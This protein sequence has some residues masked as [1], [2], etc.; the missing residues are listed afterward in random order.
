MNAPAPPAWLERLAPASHLPAWAR[1]VGLRA[2]A[3]LRVHGLPGRRE[4]AWKYTR[5]EALRR[6][7]FRAAGGPLPVDLAHLPA[8]RGPRLVFAGGYLDRASS[9]LDGLP[10][11]IAV[12]PLASLRDTAGLPQ[13]DDA[14]AGFVPALNAA[15]RTDGA[16]I[17]VA[18]GTGWDGALE[19]LHL[20]SPAADALAAPWVGIRVGEGA[21]LRVIERRTAEGA[22]LEVVRQSV[23]LGAG[24]QLDHLRMISSGAHGS[25][26]LATDVRVEAG[27]HYRAWLVAGGGALAR[28]DLRIVLAGEAAETTCAVLYA[29]GGSEQADLHVCVEHAAR[30]TRSRVRAHGVAAGRGRAVFNGR[31]HVRPGADGTD[32]RL[33]TA[34]LLLSAQAEVDAKPELE[35]Y[36]DDVK[37]AHGATVGSLDMDALYYLAS[38]GIGEQEARALLVGAFVRAVLAGL[39]DDPGAAV[40]DAAIEA[41]LAALAAEDA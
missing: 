13:D 37:C 40:L 24:A 7:E 28:E 21:R 8:A 30:R 29:A 27:A 15:A 4:E 12:Q 23:Q 5:L 19:V 14:V 26:L 6:G 31:V 35:I 3:T 41:R 20:G 2:G 16:L 9:S 36:A 10:R 33:D 39:A 25:G 22:G 38:R 1:D 34:N 18:P 32:A 17:E 11:G